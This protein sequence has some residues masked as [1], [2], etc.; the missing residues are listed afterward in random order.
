MAGDAPL[1]SS[2]STFSVDRDK[3][4]AAKLLENAYMKL[5]A[6][7]VCEKVQQPK[8]TGLTAYFVRYVRM[9]VPVTSLTE[10][11]DPSDSSFSLEEVT[12]T[13]DQWGDVLTITDVAVLTQKHPLMQ[14][15]MDLLSDNAA[16]VMDREVQNVWLT[17][18][19]VFYGG[20][21]TA[22]SELAATDYITDGLLHKVRVS[23]GRNG[24]PPRD[25]PANMSAQAKGRDAK[26]S[27]LGGSAYVAI[28][29]PAVTA[30][31]INNSAS[32]G[33]W[34][35]IA[36]YQNKMAVYNAEVGTYLGFRFVE[37][38]FVPIFKLFGDTI[39]A[40]GSTTDF[41]TGT[42][43]VTAVDGGGTLTS[44]NTYFYKC[45]R[46]DLTRG[47]AEEIS[48]AHSTQSAATADNESFTFAF[49]ATAG[50]AYDLYFDKTQANGTNADSNLG[51]VQANIAAGTTVTVTG[52]STSTTTAPANVADDGLTSQVHPIFVHGKGS[53]LWVGLQNLEFMRSKDE[54]TT[55]N[56][57]K[58][59]KTIGYKFMAKAMLP[60]N[61]RL[62]RIE[63][64]V[65][66]NV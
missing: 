48:I 4:L 39:D 45:V 43:V 30:D 58:L 63:V 15:A 5:V 51:L 31:I 53:C 36:Q 29:D 60:D 56:P 66:Y 13:L 6:H 65:K 52:V 3:F 64:A 10:G 22:R 54:A 44:A 2:T 16:R 50:Y 34:V 25:G 33:L 61:D 28:C 1:K 21:A 35:N 23:M 47:F 14:I 11:V 18:T 62:A 26:G 27:L 7:S 40:N 20:T 17:G 41:G 59:R 32:G 55:D 19:N 42:P 9:N 38:N 12:A 37:S 57:L 49:P 8:G 24:A 46:K